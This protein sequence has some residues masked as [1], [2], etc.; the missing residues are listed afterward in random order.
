MM[1]AIVTATIKDSSTS[2][3]NL[4]P[5]GTRRRRAEPQRENT[6]SNAEN[7][8]GSAAK[9]G[10]PIE[11]SVGLSVKKGEIARGGGEEIVVM[12]SIESY[13]CLVR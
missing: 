10:M 2:R 6:A 13:W 4:C 1:N 3:A 7:F 11:L 5:G 9:T 12:R 8:V